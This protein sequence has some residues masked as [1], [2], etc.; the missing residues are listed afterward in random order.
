MENWKSG[1]RGKLKI[2]KFPDL[3]TTYFI[4]KTDGCEKMEN[5][6]KQSQKND[7]YEKNRKMENG[8]TEKSLNSK[9]LQTIY[10]TRKN[11]W[12]RKHGKSRKMKIMKM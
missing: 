5:F 10:F 2:P 11:I 3:P 7:K 1:K 4:R 6:K 8:Q 12:L 9:N